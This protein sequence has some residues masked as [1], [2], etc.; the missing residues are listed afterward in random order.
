MSG[1]D[2]RMIIRWPHGHGDALAEGMYPGGQSEDPASP[3]YQDLA[4]SWW[5]GSYLA[6]PF[7]DG[8]AGGL[9]RWRLRP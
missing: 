3:W 6:M 4:G 9:V 2:W 1:P 7:A 8:P 5:R